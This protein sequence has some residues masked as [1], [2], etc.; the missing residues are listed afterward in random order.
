MRI[1]LII[2]Q[3]MHKIYWKKVEKYANASIKEANL[4]EEGI[5]EEGTNSEITSNIVLQA[6][7]KNKNFTRKKPN[8]LLVAI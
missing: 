1:K 4:V 2:F 6:V 5:R 8:I 3:M 7:R